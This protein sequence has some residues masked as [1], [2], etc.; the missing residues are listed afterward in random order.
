[1]TLIVG[2]LSITVF[3]E[4]KERK[5][6]LKYPAPYLH[7]KTYAEKPSTHKTMQSSQRS[8][9]TTKGKI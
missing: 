4:E 7:M 3:T 5:L 6:S 1:M 9:Q 8:F 2:R